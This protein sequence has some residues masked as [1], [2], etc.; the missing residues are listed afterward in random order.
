MDR[1]IEI[2]KQNLGCSPNLQPI[3]QEQDQHP[4]TAKG[5]NKLHDLK[6]QF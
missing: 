4:R 5:T 1:A 3:H 6:L 2:E